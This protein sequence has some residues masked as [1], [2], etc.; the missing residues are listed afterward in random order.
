MIN[1]SLFFGEVIL[2][3][4]VVVIIVDVVCVVANLFVAIAFTLKQVTASRSQFQ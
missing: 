3:I 1:D 4:A 2:A